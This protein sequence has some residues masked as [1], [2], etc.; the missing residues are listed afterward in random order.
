MLVFFENYLLMALE[1]IECP[2]DAMQGIHQ[3]I[4]TQTKINYLNLLL[5]AGF[6]SLDFGSF[7]S[8]KAIPQLAD[9]PEV[10]EK[11]EL[12]SVQTKLLAIV[13]NLRGAETACTYPQIQYIG[14]PFSISETFQQRN[15][16]SSI[17]DSLKT[18]EAMQQLSVAHG[19]TL[20][21]YLSMGFGNPY[22]DPWSA[23]LLIDW[24]NKMA[25]LGVKIL[26]LSDTIGIA[27]P[28]TIHEVFSN[29]IP[30]LP[31]I[32]FGAH[33][34]TT[35]DTWEEKMVAA[36]EAGCQRFD[37]AI[38]GFGGCPMAADALTGNMPM[39]NILHFLDKKKVAHGIDTSV[40]DQAMLLA[41]EV[42]PV[43]TAHS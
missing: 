3:F 8:P 19:K 34:H 14:F 29:L 40:F 36:W 16:H 9:T 20:V 33:L 30:A 41:N 17:Q 42:F 32:T 12:N 31:Q 2:R 21:V 28:S 24:S 22:G 6:H 13:A 15:T 10:I 39:E 4:P 23:D 38:K 27:N 5:R 18:V 25:A 7:V 26:S 11:L 1:L 35:P 37:G 43:E